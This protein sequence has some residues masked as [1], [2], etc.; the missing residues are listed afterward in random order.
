ML[1]LYVIRDGNGLY[2]SLI[3]TLV[4]SLHCSGLSVLSLQFRFV[5]SLFL[6]LL[7]AAVRTS[8]L[9]IGNNLANEKKRLEKSG[10]KYQKMKS[11]WSSLK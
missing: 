7:D 2:I 11:K 3:E 5:L 9:K 6:C 1:H 8:V 4:T 10:K